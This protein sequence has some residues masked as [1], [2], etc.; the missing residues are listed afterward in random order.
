MELEKAIEEEALL[1]DLIHGMD[2][3]FEQMP[4]D[5]VYAQFAYL[6]FDDIRKVCQSDDLNQQ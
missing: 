2:Q 5:D 1:D 3:E 4:F 6:T